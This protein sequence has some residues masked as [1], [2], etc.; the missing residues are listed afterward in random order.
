MSR[1][2]QFGGLWRHPDFLKLWAGQTVSLGGSLV[3]RVA[4]PFVAILTLDASPGE[5]ALL[6][7]AELVPGIVIGLF[8]G[9]WVDHLRR[10]PLMIWADLGRAVLLGSL[11][12]AAVMGLLRLELLL[13]VVFAAGLLT[14]LFEV[15]YHAY[16]PT[17]VTR[18]E[19]V[20]GNSKLEAS[21]AA[22]E[23]ASFGLGGW[24]VQALTAPIAILVD[25]I[26]FLVSAACLGA[27]QTPEPVSHDRIEPQT[28]WLA[29]REG[30]RLLLHDPVLRA[31]AGARTTLSF[32]IH[33]WLS[34]LLLFLTR[35]LGLDPGVVGVL[36]AVG[37]V[38]SLVGATLAERVVRRLGLGPTLILTLCITSAGLLLVPLAAGP[39]VVVVGLVGAQQLADG[40][41]TIY[42]IHETSLIQATVPERS[43]GR[44]T[45]SL[46]VVGWSAMLGGT[47][48]GGLLGEVLGPRPTMCVGAVGALPAVLWLL[49][50]PVRALH[51]IP[52]VSEDAAGEGAAAS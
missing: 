46:R 49:W 35:G 18:D 2:Q 38:C 31:L 8:A 40:P 30:V 13:V 5:V 22:I 29:I 41:A 42:Q 39:F 14:A 32:F 47:I 12:L 7:M 51:T 19:L 36:F 1:L 52:A 23:V 44:V 28:T 9:V 43:L 27:I 16:L 6:R 20:E 3:S 37:G 21:G 17:L 50:S 15:A 26:S 10:R 24:L 45:A 33:L 11:P 25:A 34:M 4:L 48:V